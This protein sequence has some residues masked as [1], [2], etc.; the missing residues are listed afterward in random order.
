MIEI[1]DKFLGIK[2]KSLGVEV[3]YIFLVFFVIFVFLKFCNFFFCFYKR[4]YGMS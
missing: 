4:G 3:V 1:N 2:V